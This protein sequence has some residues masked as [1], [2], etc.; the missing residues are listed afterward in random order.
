M[1][2]GQPRGNE[3]DGQCIRTSQIHAR[4]LYTCYSGDTGDVS[5]SCGYGMDLVICSFGTL[6]PLSLW[7]LDPRLS[8]HTSHPSAWDL[9]LLALMNIDD[10]DPRVQYEN[11]EVEWEAEQ[12]QR[13]NEMG[14]T[15]HVPQTSSAKMTLPFDGKS[16][17]L[18]FSH[19]N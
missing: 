18:N 6:F 16:I 4:C 11:A 14:D 5:R 17:H 10:D 15:V 3:Q 7:I 9:P 19:M 12:K 13:V 8:C 2:P 1:V